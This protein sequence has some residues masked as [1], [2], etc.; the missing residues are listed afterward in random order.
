MDPLF[1]GCYMIEM[2]QRSRCFD[3][4]GRNVTW[5]SSA[6]FHAIMLPTDS[7]VV[8]FLSQGLR[9]LGPM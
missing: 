8:S 9:N 1:F 7:L 4:V 3:P 6:D 2:T 5:R